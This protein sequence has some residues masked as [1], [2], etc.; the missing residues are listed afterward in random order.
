MTNHHDEMQVAPDPVQAEDL[1]RRLHARLTSGDRSHHRSPSERQLD[2]LDLEHSSPA[3]AKAP[4]DHARRRRLVMAAAAVVII[5]AAGIAINSRSA[6][7]EDLSVTGTPTPTGEEIGVTPDVIQ[8]GDG[9]VALRIM[10]EGGRLYVLAGHVQSEA[11]LLGRPETA[12]LAAFDDGGRG[13]WR[14]E[15]D[16]S[17][18]DVVVANGDPW[19]I[20]RDGTLTR[21][22]SSDGRLLGQVLLSP[23]HDGRAVGA[24]GA[25]WVQIGD[26]ADPG[27]DGMRLERVAPDL[28]VTT[29]DLPAGVASGDSPGGVT[30][31]AGAVW[32][33]LKQ[34]GVAVIDPGTTKVT[35][36]S[37][38][39]I[40]HEVIDVAFDG[41]V[42]YVTSGDRVSSVVD[43]AVV[44][45]V[46]TGAVRYLG[47]ISGAFGVLLDDGL[48]DALEKGAGGTGQFLVLRP[49]DP[50]ASTPMQVSIPEGARGG[51]FEIDGEAW[52]EIG[53][54]YSLRRIELIETPL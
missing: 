24:F 13:L 34:G 26:V 51:V 28:S 48:A 44:A 25:V 5:G 7:D 22:S 40:G 14:I 37:V 47:P 12:V 15:L 35:V 16:A 23:G 11:D 21:L 50:M 8:L 53:R 49:S 31:G 4:G 30:A 33:P 6:R 3:D 41:D 45:T 39:D 17:P 27:P 1:R 9:L 18:S 54:N 46:S 29:I 52:W 42:A 38:D 19:V 43:G 2:P 10:E 36:L 32:V 20:H